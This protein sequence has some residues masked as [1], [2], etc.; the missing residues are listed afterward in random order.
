MDT[1][2]GSFPLSYN[3]NSLPVPF[4]NVANI[5]DWHKKNLHCIYNRIWSFS[6]QV[7]INR[8]CFVINRSKKTWLR[9]SPTSVSWRHTEHDTVEGTVGLSQET[10]VPASALLVLQPWGESPQLQ[11]S[12]TPPSVIGFCG[13]GDGSNWASWYFLAWRGMWMKWGKKLWCPAPV[14]DLNWF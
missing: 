9:F 8:Y 12:M 5:P 10:C 6:V 1:K 3:G 14:F 13:G 2:S 11:A 7:L 4:Q